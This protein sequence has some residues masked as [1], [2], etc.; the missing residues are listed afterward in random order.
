MA[1]HD[2][3]GTVYCPNCA[4]IKEKMTQ[5]QI[6]EHML[7]KREAELDKEL[8]LLRVSKLKKFGT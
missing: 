6:W 1:C 5:L 4:I 8:G 3:L 2:D 7:K